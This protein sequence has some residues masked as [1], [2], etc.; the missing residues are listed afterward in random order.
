[1]SDSDKSNDS[2]SNSSVAGEVLLPVLDERV[3]ETDEP[4]TSKQY[5]RNKLATEK[6]LKEDSSN[7]FMVGSD[8]A[9]ATI[10]DE[11]G[12]H[13]QSNEDFCD[14]LIPD[15]VGCHFPCKICRGS[16]CS[17]ECR[18]NRKYEYEAIE[19][20]NSRELMRWSPYLPVPPT[21]E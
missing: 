8:K 2:N 19:F 10:Y 15:C 3:V 11:K 18:Q 9:S 1:M 7:N 12:I 17:H 20:E 16:K 6:A 5:R 13:K 21:K 14:C 4:R